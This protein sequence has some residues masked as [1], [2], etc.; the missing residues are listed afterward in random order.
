MFDPWVGKI[1]W[2]RRWQPTPLLLPGKFHGR[3][4]LVDY[5][6]RDCKESD[7]TEQLHFTPRQKQKPLP[8]TEGTRNSSLS[9]SAP[10]PPSW[11]RLHPAAF[12]PHSQRGNK[13]TGWAGHWP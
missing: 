11:T 4:S 6:P 12:L 8:V 5:S 2:R 13:G 10:P 9:S 1:P 7:T 3:R